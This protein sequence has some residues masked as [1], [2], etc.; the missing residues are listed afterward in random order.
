MVTIDRYV[1]KTEARSF[2]SWRQE[3]LSAK[4]NERKKVIEKR[5][6]ERKKERGAININDVME[7]DHL[8]EFHLT[9]S[10]DRKFLII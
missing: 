5:K 2:G 6:I 4:S 3:N 10:V 9:E 7:N 8:T 1:T